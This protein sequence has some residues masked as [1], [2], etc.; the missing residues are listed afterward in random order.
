M[1]SIP[2]YI[3]ELGIVDLPLSH[4]WKKCESDGFVSGN[5]EDSLSDVN[6]RGQL[7]LACGFA[8]W[9]AWRLS[10][11]DAHLPL[12]PTSNR[13]PLT[14]ASPR[15]LLQY[16]EAVWAGLIAEQYTRE[17]SAPVLDQGDFHRVRGPIRVAI[18]ELKTALELTWTDQFLFPE[19][20]V[21]N[22]VAIDVLPDPKPFK[23][24][25]TA[26][27]KRMK[28]L[29]PR[30]DQTDELG[31]LGCPITRESLDLRFD[32]TLEHTEEYV[33]LFLEGLDPKENPYLRTP[34]EMIRA[35][36][37][38]QPYLFTPSVLL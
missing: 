29:F 23:K 1:F 15:E 10:K 27:L 9:V 12:A 35:G 22:C 31:R 2:K 20:A 8:E 11:H 21:L 24:W 37:R 19:A 5:L 14:V 25:R 28:K 7:A 13:Q 17:I 6:H 30:I 4:N 36:F 34:E 32:Y 26:V 38:G 3:E 33:A 16:I 18:H